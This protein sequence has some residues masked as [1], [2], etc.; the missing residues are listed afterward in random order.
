VENL[1]IGSTETLSRFVYESK[2]INAERVHF[3]A[4]FDPGHEVSV[5]RTSSLSESEIWLDGDA[6]SNSRG[7]ALG[8]GDMAVQDIWGEGFQIRPDEPPPRH[9][10]IFGWELSDKDACRSAA[11]QLAAIAVPRLRVG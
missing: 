4:F 2:K 1:G 7:P 9:A 10:L 6:A 11:Q 5:G 3:R 8:R